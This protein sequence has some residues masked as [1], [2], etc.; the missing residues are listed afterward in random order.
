MFLVQ[1]GGAGARLS[2]GMSARVA[3]LE[4]GP[5]PAAGTVLPGTP[6]VTSDDHLSVA[7]IFH[8]HPYVCLF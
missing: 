5:Q 6:L 2:L 3:A 4:R 8:K 1:T 7:A